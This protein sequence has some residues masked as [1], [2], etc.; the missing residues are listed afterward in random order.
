MCW[1]KKTLIINWQPLHMRNHGCGDT[2]PSCFYFQNQ[3]EK[4]PWSATMNH[5]G[6][7]PCQASY[8]HKQKHTRDNHPCRHLS[9]HIPQD[10]CLPP[11]AIIPNCP[12][13]YH[14]RQSMHYRSHMGVPHNCNHGR[15]GE[16]QLRRSSS[17]FL[18]WGM[19]WVSVV[20]WVWWHF[21]VTQQPTGVTRSYA[22]GRDAADKEKRL[23][24]VLECPGSIC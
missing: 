17:Y 24:M 5:E 21:G 3:E 6:L 9:L 16:S 11:T 15:P 20:W 10:G 4:L 13:H 1:A 12:R 8:I 23:K 18:C 7:V 22:Y 2:K 19:L 14:D